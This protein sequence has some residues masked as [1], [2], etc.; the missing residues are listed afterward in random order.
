M[1]DDSD[2]EP[3]EDEIAKMRSKIKS[4]ATLLINLSDYGIDVPEN[5]TTTSGQIKIPNALSQGSLGI[6]EDIMSVQG[7]IHDILEFL[8]KDTAAAGLPSLNDVAS[9]YAPPDDIPA[10]YEYQLSQTD[11]LAELS[12]TL[13]SPVGK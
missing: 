13:G 5:T 9:A 10:K 12:P 8:G 4:G 6:E 2:A 3:S 7:K 1:T 11:Y